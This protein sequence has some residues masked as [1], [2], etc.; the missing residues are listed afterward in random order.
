M[1]LLKS[2]VAILILVGIVAGQT[3]CPSE[4]FVEDR[5]E[6]TEMVEQSV[7]MV[8]SRLLNDTTIAN[9]S[10]TTMEA[11]EHIGA[12]VG[13]TTSTNGFVFFQEAVNEIAA[14]TFDACSAPGRPRPRPEE[15]PTLTSSFIALTDAGN[16]TQARE[17]YG[18]LL[19]LRDILSAE[20]G[21]RRRDDSFE[22]LEEFFDSLDGTRL[23]TIF[24]YIF[25]HPI[26]LGFAVDDTGSMSAEISSVQRLIR[27]FITTERTEPIA[28]ILTTFND[29]DVGT[30]QIYSSTSVDELT[31]LEREVNALRAHGGGD[32]PELGM[33]GILNALSL[34][35]PDSNV[36]V[37]TDASPKDVERKDEVIAKAVELHNS[38]HFF[39]SRDGCGDFS[40]YMDVAEATF[41]VV[42]N[43][44]DE[45]E[46]FA[47]FADRVGRFFMGDDGDARK[48][49]ASSE[50]C[51]TFSSSL[52]TT[53]INILFTSVTHQ[54]NVTS[55]SGV[56]TM[57]ST[58]GSVATY[59]NDEPEIGEYTMCSLGRF[60]HAISLTST[61]DFFV[62]HFE[63]SFGI[64]VPELFPIGTI[65]VSQIYL[66]LI[67]KHLNNQ[68]LLFYNCNLSLIVFII[69]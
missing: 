64:P 20:V 19:C 51:F 31:E 24:A 29:P 15:I 8:F 21:R 63:K 60:N 59:S 9:G 41:G 16:V 68:L 55:P 25:L 12:I 43:R 27:S 44:I 34:A 69:T 17:I 3:T 7:R 45:F 13:A 40:P 50:H 62:E 22:L 61:L 11:Y 32:C 46:A 48:R 4:E 1:S 53:S 28:Y 30:P 66:P 58:S 37:L 56:K 65:Y 5:M 52:F 26:T 6:A 33:T 35:N 23:A 39:L 36:I 42:V 47:E 2:T 57:I 14:A 10:L 18:K 54:I 38:I 49:D 67:L